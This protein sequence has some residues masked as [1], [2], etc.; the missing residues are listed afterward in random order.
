MCGSV[1]KKKSKSFF[2][3]M[4]AN[5]FWGFGFTATIWA[6]G[7]FTIP[8][9]LF[10]RFFIVGM[11]GLA[12]AGL[13]QKALLKPMLSITLVPAV[14][15][16]IEILFQVW[17]LRFTSATNA[18]FLTVSY[19]LMVP[20][21]EWIF[22]RVRI[23]AIHTFW[24]S[25][26]F[27]GTVIMLEPQNLQVNKGDLLMLVSALGASLHMLSID[28]LGKSEK[29]LFFANTMQCFWGAVLLLPILLFSNDPWN[30]PSDLKPWIGLASLTFGS[31]MLAFY[32]Q[33]RAQRTLSPSVSSLLFLAESPMA[34]GF[35]FVLLQ[36]RLS[37]LQS[38]GCVLVLIAAGGVAFL[39]RPQ[40]AG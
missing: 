12:W 25:L 40:R 1:L 39:S 14:F 37:F 4:V 21:L 10:V 15:L 20:L 9:I 17:G 8:Q 36:E 23:T 29:N 18:G 34:A 26:G 30:W 2:E 35:G 33:M 7:S 5:L 19:I 11:A 6:L 22:R 24:V 3:A 38:I 28:S 31:T 13:R 27:M 16:I 32:F